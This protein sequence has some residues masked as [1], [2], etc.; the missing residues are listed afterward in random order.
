MLMPITINGEVYL[1]SKE[2]CQ[3]LGVTRQ[4]LENLVKE[5]R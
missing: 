1:T 4:T 2:A 5:G 3:R